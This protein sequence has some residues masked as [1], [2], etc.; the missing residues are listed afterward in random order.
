MANELE[1]KS[2]GSLAPVPLNLDDVAGDAALGGKIGLGDISIPFVSIIQSNSPQCNIDSPAYV[3]GA[4]SGG[5]FVSVINKLYDGR[6]AGANIILC[7]YERSLIQWGD[8]E[9]GQ[10]GFFG[11][12]DIDDP[13]K[14][15][16]I[17]DEKGR[18]V[19]PNGN[20]LQDTSY[21]YV[22]IESDGTWH[23][24]VYPMKSTAMKVSRKLN[25]ILA[26][27][28]I[29]GTKQLAPRFLYKWNMKTIKEAKA[30]NVWSSPMFTMGEMCTLE[31]YNAAKN[32]AKIAATQVLRKAIVRGET[33]GGNTPIDDNVPF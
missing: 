27:T 2:E 24:A 22:L 12:Y 15:T 11:S 16:A 25:S 17:Q 14:N 10:G 6:G 32:Y 9:K 29:P 1:L 3:P 8:R 19:L 20:Y 26:T 18:F 28:Y 4:T 13:I 7:Y 21:N 33:T 23:Q 5:I 31:Q 30:Q